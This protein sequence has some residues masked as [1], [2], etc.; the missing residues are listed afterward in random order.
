MSITEL[1]HNHGENASVPEQLQ[2]AGDF[3]IAA[4]IFKQLG[5]TTRIRIFWLLCHYEECVVNIAA[6]LDMSS[7]AVAHHLRPLRD[8]GLIVS[9][10]DGKEVYYKAADTPLGKLAHQMIEQ[11]MEIACPKSSDTPL[12]HHESESK[13]Q[14]DQ[15]AYQEQTEIIRQIHTQLLEHLDQSFTI[16]SLA[17]Q[18]LMNPTTLK[19]MFKSVYGMS[20]A[21]HIKEHRMIEA[22]KLLRETDMK[23]AEIA[24][25]VGYDSPSKF[26]TAFKETYQVLPKEYRKK[27][28]L[29]QLFK[30]EPIKQNIQTE[31]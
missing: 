11:V 27:H 5:D 26:T 17:K 29:K 23:I 28:L 22:A 30:S 12:S 14:N 13:Y 16:E 24:G 8:N 21:A 7:P 6:V 10:R 25:R 20:I 2:L 1:P 15:P 31:K 19:S 9:H 3:R 4:E 18:H